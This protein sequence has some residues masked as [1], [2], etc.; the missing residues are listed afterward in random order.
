MTRD[1]PRD[2]TGV[3][4]QKRNL[5]GENSCRAWPPAKEEEAGGSFFR[6]DLCRLPLGVGEVLLLCSLG[7]LLPT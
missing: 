2:A 3:C 1:R 5:A 4:E 6:V 7:S